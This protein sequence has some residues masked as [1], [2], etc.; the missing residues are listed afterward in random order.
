ME[1]HHAAITVTVRRVD[2][3]GSASISEAALP[4]EF[5]GVTEIAARRLRA[6]R[7]LGD[8]FAAA[9]SAVGWLGAVQSQDYGGAKWA[10]A[11][12]LAGATDVELDRLFDEGAFLR[13]HVMRPTWHFVLPEDI[14]WL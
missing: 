4:A 7:L 14:L 6:Q 3:K 5:E 2:G 12:R 10:L 9:A 13:T 8:P 11:Q 1:S